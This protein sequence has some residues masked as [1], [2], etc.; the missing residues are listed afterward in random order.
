[1]DDNWAMST[2]CCPPPP[3]ARASGA[4]PHRPHGHLSRRQ[5]GRHPSGDRHLSGRGP[6]PG[7]SREPAGEGLPLPG[8]VHWGRSSSSPTAPPAGADDKAGVAEIVTACEYLL[9]HPEVPHRAIAVCFTPDEEVGKGADH[10]DPGKVPRQGR[11]TPWTAA[12]WARSS[13]R[14]STPPP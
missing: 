11:P 2:P 1:M 4:G 13:T 6:A 12:S 10:F 7:Q 3:G 5:R 9:A 8:A 14:T